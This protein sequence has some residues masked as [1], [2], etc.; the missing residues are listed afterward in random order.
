[1]KSPYLYGELTEELIKALPDEP[2]TFAEALMGDS[3]AA[4]R[5]RRLCMAYG[6]ISEG[7]LREAELIK[8][9]KP[10]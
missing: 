9:G 6:T 5:I 8:Y 1:M 10:K 7:A 4:K 3:P 2:M